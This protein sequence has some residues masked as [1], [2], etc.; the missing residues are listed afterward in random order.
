[1]IDAEMPATSLR[2]YTR[3][4]STGWRAVAALLTSAATL[5][6]CGGRAE[7]PPD[8]RIRPQWR[9]VSLPVPAGATG[10]PVLR[11]AAHCQDRWYAVGAIAAPDGATVPAAW[12][13]D[14]AHAWTSLRMTARTYYGKQNVLYSAACRDGRLAAIGGK[15]GG[16]HGNPR[17]SSW[18]HLPD[19]SMDEVLAGF[20]LYGGPYAVNVARMTAG[21]AGWLIVG[22]RISG[23]AT[24]TS[25]DSAEF[26]IVEGAPE[27][28][29]DGAG[30]T[31]AFDAVPAAGGWLAAGGIIR[32]G[33]I[34]R[35]PLAWT[36]SDGRAWTR[37][38]VPATDE[39]EEFQRVVLAADGT[40][41]AVGLRGRAFA[42]WRREAGEWTAAGQFG[43][44]AGK[45]VAMV[46]GL[47]VAGDD[48]LA[49]TSDGTDHALWLSADGG[50]S[51]RT[52]QAPAAA[53][54]G[55][56]R[57]VVVAAGGDRALVL[58]DDG[59]AG[60]AWVATAPLSGG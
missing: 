23:A 42:A 28:A 20:E 32:K 6:A 52:V 29:S 22:N 24:W 26:T 58:T 12:T 59:R 37:H 51:W 17:V 31:W 9:E 38:E 47:A 8:D 15:V 54:A 25:P 48:L 2:P 46:R 43:A 18:H 56:D 40:P 7:P 60:R 57:A 11:D 16:A 14:D 50:R 33:R 19:G 1:M 21:P 10:R 35:D 3:R 36:S 5:A 4:M 44:A 49:A 13:S 27:L 34:D 41:V 53:P 55:A 30:E 39:Y 45:G